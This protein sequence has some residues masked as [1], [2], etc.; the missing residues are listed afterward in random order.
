MINVQKPILCTNFSMAA[1]Q[2]QKNKHD[3]TLKGIFCHYMY[4]HTD[5]MHEYCS[6]VFDFIDGNEE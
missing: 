6:R 3:F 1:L 4:V 2:N 5:F